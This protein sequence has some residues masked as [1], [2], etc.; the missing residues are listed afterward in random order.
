MEHIGVKLNK[1][2]NVLKN[3]HLILLCGFQGYPTRTE[4]NHILR[5]NVIKEK[6]TVIHPNFQMGFAD[7]PVEEQYTSTF[8][9]V[10]IGSGAEVIEKHLTSWKSYGNGRF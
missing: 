8:S 1:Q 3:K 7:H 5:M 6:V 9:L 10:A 4:D 2:S